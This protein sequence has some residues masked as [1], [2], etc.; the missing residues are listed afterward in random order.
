M[1]RLTFIVEMTKSLA[2]PI[3]AIILAFVL[4]RPLVR[5][6]SLIRRLKYG[7][8][9]INFEKEIRAVE[10]LE[11]R[12][13]KAETAGTVQSRGIDGEKLRELARLSPSG[14]ITAAWIE[15]EQALMDAGHRQKLFREDEAATRDPVYI[16]R[17]L[18]LREATDWTTYQVFAELYRL[19]NLAMH[20]AV[21]ITEAQAIEFIDLAERMIAK[22][23]RLQTPSV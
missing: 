19:R 23:E 4:R 5:L 22:L 14:A 11:G 17:A 6:M 9:E 13:P 7:D 12:L 18:A 15:V 16:A 10:K 8:L 20:S 2:W 1:D 21:Q 3:A